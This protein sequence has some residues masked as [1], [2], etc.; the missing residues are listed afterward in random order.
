MTNESNKKSSNWLRLFQFF[1]IWILANIA[2]YLILVI[3]FY[4]ETIGISMEE[5]ER[6]GADDPLFTLLIEVSIS[7]ATLISFWFIKQKI[8]KESIDKFFKWNPMGFSIGSGLGFILILLCSLL[9][10]TFNLVKPEYHSLN[11]LPF[12]ILVF[13][14]VAVTEEVMFRGYILNNLTEKLSKNL[15]II[16]SSLI[17][18]AFHLGNPHFGLIGFINIFLSGILMAI[19]YLNSKDLWAPIGVHFTWNL[20]QAVLGF[21]VSGRN[22]TGVFKLNYLSRVDYLTGG[23][24]GIE[25][26][27]LTT[28]ISLTAI[29]IT[30]KILRQYR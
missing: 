3:P 23:I 1:G 20:T 8:E 6:M 10:F 15:A 28:A 17:F 14:L 4:S 12:L 27:L 25:G 2:T 18:A 29:S 9:M 16:L 13:M 30:G 26:S 5:Y 22:D 7:V 19:V 11:N 21:A 24:F